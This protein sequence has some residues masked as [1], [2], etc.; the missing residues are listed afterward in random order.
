MFPDRFFVLNQLETGAIPSLIYSGNKSHYAKWKRAIKSK[1]KQ[2]GVKDPQKEIDIL[3]ANTKNRPHTVIV[4]V[5]EV[6]QKRPRDTLNIIWKSL[7][8][9]NG[10]KTEVTEK[11]L[12]SVENFQPISDAE[13]DSNILALKS[14]LLLSQKIQVQSKDY[15]D[16]VH[17]SSPF[18]LRTLVKKTPPAFRNKWRK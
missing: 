14:L 3:S 13:T 18:G 2:L 16:L 10:S 17:F 8:L 1:L 6:G 12:K 15:P 4:D 7:D 5:S 11:L 9:E